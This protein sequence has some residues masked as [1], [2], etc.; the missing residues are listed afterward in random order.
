MRKGFPCRAER[1]S[2]SGL[3]K[4]AYRSSGERISEKTKP[5]G[6]GQS[7]AE[8]EVACGRQARRRRGG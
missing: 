5:I 4:S 6:I 7:S 8:K 3:Q 2:L 1:F